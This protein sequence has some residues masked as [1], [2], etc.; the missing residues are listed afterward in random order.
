MEEELDSGGTKNDF[1]YLNALQ[2][3]HMQISNIATAD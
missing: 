2:Y 1:C 3:L